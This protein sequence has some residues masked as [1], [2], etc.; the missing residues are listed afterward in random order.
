MKP[1]EPAVVT[2]G[3]IH[4]GTKHNVIGNA[5]DLQITVRSYSDEVRTQIHEAIKR[6]AK[7]VALGARAEEPTVKISEGTPS[8]WND[9][10]LTERLVPVFQQALGDQHVVPSELSMGGE[11]FSRYGKAGVPILMF[12]LGTVE[13][14]RLDRYKQLGIPAPSLHSSKYYPD[15]EPT[16]KAGITAM[17]SAVLEL[18]KPAEKK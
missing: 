17:A 16:L 5:C 2:V 3:S 12:R 18:L 9:Q 15:A 13:Q 10:D 1:I 6:K 8:L 7:A 14:R 11:D 4:G